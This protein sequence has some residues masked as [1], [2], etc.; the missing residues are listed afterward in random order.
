MS[1]ATRMKIGK[2]WV[3][4]ELPPDKIMN[5]H[6]SAYPEITAKLLYYRGI[7]DHESAEKFLN[8]DYSRDIHDPYMARDMEK[9]VGRIEKAISDGERIVVVADYDAD[10]IPGGA[11]LYSFFTKIGYENFEVYIPDR[12][13]ESYGLSVALV[14]K[15]AKF[16]AKLIITVDCGITDIAPVL[17][18]KELGVDVIV[19]DHHL[20]HAELPGAFAVINNKREDDTYP[21]KFLCGAATAWKLVCALLKRPQFKIQDGWEKWLLD[22]AGISTICDMVSLTGE[23]RAIAHFG[24]KVLSKTRRPGLV[25]LLSK[26]RIDPE[27]ITEDD[28]G[29]TIGPRINIASRMAH[30]EEAFRLLTTDS[31]PEARAISDSLE[32]RN[33]ERRK[34]VQDILDDIDS[35]FMEVELPSLIVRGKPEWRLGVLGLTCMRLVEKYGRPVCLWTINGTGEVKGSIRSDGTV[36][37]LKLFEA[38]GGEEFFNDY[39][40][41]AFSGGFTLNQNKAEEF[42]SRMIVAYEK[43]KD[44]ESAIAGV[45]ID[46]VLNLSDLTWDFYNQIAKFAPFGMDNP[47]PNFLFSNIMVESVREFGKNGNT[48]IE[49]IFK[50]ESGRKI[51]AIEFFVNTYSYGDF[52]IKAG[53]KIDLVATIERSNY[54]GANDLRLRVVDIKEATT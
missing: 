42:E 8:P 15:L 21:F 19:T 6:L 9:T 35:A 7:E 49:L 27:F 22:L 14:E 4:R 26:A 5:N 47:K 43:V 13:T 46:H 45:S 25:S 31:W 2:Q 32:K 16:G 52:E 51:K 34:T 37:V 20:P 29:F 38:A 1:R 11:I 53:K 40:G 48:H 54:M 12:Y 44:C 18:A 41:H 28:I 39:G 50:N 17:C 23:N 36:H 24:L 3:I 10:G 33:Q 30:G